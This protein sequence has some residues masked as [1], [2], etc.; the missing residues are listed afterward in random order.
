MKFTFE[1]VANM[2]FL[3]NDGQVW[4]AWNVEEFT[5]RKMK[6]AMNK[7]SKEYNGTVEFEKKF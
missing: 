1:K 3:T 2:I 5:E 4:K 7:I 6:N